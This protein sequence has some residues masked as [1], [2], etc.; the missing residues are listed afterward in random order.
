MSEVNHNK[1]VVIGLDGASFSLIMP[2]IKEGKLP[3]LAKLIQQGAW[4]NLKS[5]IPYNSAPAWS[6]FITGKNPGKHGIFDFTYHTEANYDIKFISSLRRRG[7]SFWKI[8]GE[9][10]KRVCA[11][12]VPI[13]YPPEEVN[14][15]MI[16]GITAPEVNEK[17]FYPRELFK[18]IVSKVGMYKIKPFP[19]DQIRQNRFDNVFG[20]MDSVLSQHHNVANYLFQKKDWD[21]FSMVF[22]TTDR[23]QHFFWQHMD[24]NHPFHDPSQYTKY[25]DSVFKIY[26]K[27]DG[28]IGSFLDQLD[29]N[30]TVLILSDH[31][32]GANSDKMFYLNNW[33]AHEGL[34]AYKGASNMG[35]IKSGFFKKSIFLLKK[36]IPRKYKNKVRSLFPW[37]KSKVETLYWD[38]RIDWSLT[39]AFSY[40][41][42]G[43]IWI[44][45]KGREAKGI[46]N[47]GKEY[48]DLRNE[49]IKRALNF[50]DPETGE[51]VFSEAH[52]KEEIYSGECMRF[53][54]DVVLVQKEKKYMYAYR[55]SN[56]SRSK[57]PIE[58]VT[59]KETR[60]DAVQ[61]GSHRED[62]ILIIKGLPLQQGKNISGARLIDVAPT[63]LYLMGVP[64]PKDMD[65]GVVVE[66]I[67]PDYLKSNPLN[68]SKAD[69]S[70]TT[71]IAQSGYTKE[72][73]KQ[74][75]EALKSLGYIE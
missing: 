4:G 47:D 23:V 72:E 58:K 50:K 40:D 48:E 70:T 9:Q 55:N 5:T 30:T 45:L 59:L 74:V 71:E 20:E 6:S 57:L 75:E 61:M 32:A 24:Q 64:I 54:P 33:L 34:L 65:G 22:T 1:V 56:Q 67:N 73:E 68:Y 7:K 60:R 44:N 8:L 62:G 35:A 14:G 12:N 52:K 11:F 18:E 51:H 21:F 37:L 28:I 17:I 13:T 66:A 31:G 49:I 69:K 27:L 3:I 15:C 46:V 43:L 63:I 42:N 26:K 29:K 16:S 41:S 36:H 39:K 38:F 53:A 2:W 19:R 10:G 25:G